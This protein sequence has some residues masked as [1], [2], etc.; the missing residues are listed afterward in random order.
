MN[1][2]R[3]LSRSTRL[4]IARERESRGNEVEGLD[5]R[6]VHFNKGKRKT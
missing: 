2:E 6:L 1:L 4:K 5:G 3:F